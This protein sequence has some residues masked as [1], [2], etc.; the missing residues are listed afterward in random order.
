MEDFDQKISK[1][2]IVKVV[3]VNIFL[4]MIIQVISLNTVV[5]L[6]VTMYINHPNL[7]HKNA[8]IHEIVEI[9]YRYPCFRNI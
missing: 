5:N 6:V 3:K 2:Y 7:L 4:Y 8:T 1:K 9:N